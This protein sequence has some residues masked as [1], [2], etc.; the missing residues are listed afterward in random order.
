MLETKKV[1]IGEERAAKKMPL[2]EADVKALLASVKHVVI[3]KGKASRA[4]DA[5]DAKPDDLRGPTGNFRA[6]MVRRG[7]TLL[8]GFSETALK[9]LLAG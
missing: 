5:G 4:L 3:A 8:V 7:K 9:D 6:P 1:E 2:T